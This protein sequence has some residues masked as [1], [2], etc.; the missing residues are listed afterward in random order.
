[1][2][3]NP[4]KPSCS[5]GDCVI[6]EVPVLLSNISLCVTMY[7]PQ[8]ESNQKMRFYAIKPVFIPYI[9]SWAKFKSKFETIRS[10]KWHSL[11]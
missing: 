4:E 3:A 9:D 10:G 11:V 6:H 2:A 1:M 5:K 7:H 8:K